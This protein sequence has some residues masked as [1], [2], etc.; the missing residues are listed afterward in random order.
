MVCIVFI[1][2][3]RQN[4]QLAQLVLQ[5]HYGST[6]FGPSLQHYSTKRY[7]CGSQLTPRIGY[8]CYYVLIVLIVVIC[9]IILLSHRHMHCQHQSVAL[10]WQGIRNMCIFS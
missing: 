3:I 8:T 5:K 9:L 6:V 10:I 4:I 1:A 7:M 2:K